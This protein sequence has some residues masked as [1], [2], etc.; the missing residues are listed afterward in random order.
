MSKYQNAKIENRRLY[1]YVYVCNSQINN[2]F[3]CFIINF[4]IEILHDLLCLFVPSCAKI[5]LLIKKFVKFNIF[6]M[7][8][9]ERNK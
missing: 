8:D 3:M 9:N 4:N 1:M 6:S 5:V 7:F 2:Y